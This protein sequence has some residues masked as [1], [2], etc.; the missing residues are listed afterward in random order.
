MPDSLSDVIAERLRYFRRAAGLSY[1]ELAERCAGGQLTATAIGNLE[2][3]STKSRAGR[4]VTVQELIILSE[5]L[6]L[7]SPLELLLANVPVVQLVPDHPMGRDHAVA[8]FVGE[9]YATSQITRLRQHLGLI[10]RWA[11]EADYADQLDGLNDRI[12]SDGAARQRQTEILLARLRLSMQ[13][14]GEALP[15]LPGHLDGV[16]GLMQQLREADLTELDEVSRG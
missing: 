4:N 9:G 1:D 3:R 7:A 6:K 11:Q 10:R 14:L 15:P 5:A 16:N 13:D 12:A 2:R 8:W